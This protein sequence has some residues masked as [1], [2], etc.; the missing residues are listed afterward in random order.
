MFGTICAVDPKPYQFTQQELEAI[1]SLAKFLA[2]TLDLESIAARF[3]LKSAALESA[4]N[5]VAITNH[6]GEIQWINPA[7]SSLTGFTLDEIRE[8][9]GK[10]VDANNRAC[11]SHQAIWKAFELGEF[12]HGELVSKHKT[13]E[14]YYEEMTLTPV[15]NTQGVITHYIAIKQDITARKQAEERLDFL[16]FFDPLTSLP[17]RVK[18]RD[19]LN[20]LLNRGK[21]DQR[22]AV[23]SLDLDR[24]KN[25][26]ETL[27]HTIGDLLLQATAERIVERVGTEAIVA[28]ISGDEF[29]VI[30]PRITDREAVAHIAEQL[31]ESISQPFYL[32]GYELYIST[33]IGVSF[34]PEDGQDAH[35][36]I[37][38]AD[39]AMYHAK[40]SGRN[41]HKVYTPEMNT[42]SRIE[43][44]NHLRRALDK[45]ELQLYYQPKVD[46]RSGQVSGMEALLRWIHP[47]LG[48]VSPEIFI[49]IAEDIGMIGEIGEWVMRT[50][51]KQIKTWQDAGLP[52]LSVAVNISVSQFQYGNLVNKVKSALQDTGLDAKWLEL[53]ITESIIIQNTDKV[54]SIL[55]ELKD[56][57]I[58]IS[59]DDFGTGYS[60]LSYLQRLP[61]DALKIDRSFVKDIQS[62]VDD[63]AIARA[64]ISLAHNLKLQVIAEGVETEE[65]LSFLQ[66]QQCDAMQGYLFS[67]PLPPHD[68][69]K[70]LMER[71]SLNYN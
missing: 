5:A 59:I 2:H 61:I 63:A 13:G 30:L 34:Y 41:K 50:A 52:Q 44:E 70:L 51:C 54:I 18:F 40:I 69:E 22:L 17:N 53:E 47:E 31:T 10:I 28:R 21:Q 65:Q 9:R 26:N 23:F 67:R 58:K 3:Q 48:F 20:D 27:G 32:N 64:V 62:P 66:S 45:N 38:H 1:I 12:W 49:P 25:I 7:Y 56:M 60:S 42:S 37:T 36:L 46:L 57:G 19:R 8:Q 24:F 35:T 11:P 4:A 55:L 71:K 16:A 15:Q 29:A 14:R 43:M 39:V 6:T 68:F 33:S